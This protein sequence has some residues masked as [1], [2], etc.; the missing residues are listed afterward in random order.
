VRPNI[1][2]ELLRAWRDARDLSQK[3][4]AERLGVA[5]AT[6]SEWESGRKL[7]CLEGISRIESTTGIRGAKFLEASEPPSPPPAVP[8]REEPAP[9]AASPA[10]VYIVFGVDTRG[11]EVAAHYA[12]AATADGAVTALGQLRETLPTVPF[13]IKRARVFSDTEGT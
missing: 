1:G 6:V 2:G 11:G 4:M 12:V 5:Q 13:S 10:H 8:V 9:P 3:Q 7:P